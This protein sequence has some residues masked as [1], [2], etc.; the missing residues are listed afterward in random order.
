MAHSKDSALDSKLNPAAGS[1]PGKRGHGSGE[2]PQV[3][4]FFSQLLSLIQG[5]SLFFEERF[6]LKTYITLTV[7]FAFS[8]AVL[9]GPEADIQ[10]TLLATLGLLLFF[11]ELRIMD[12]LKDYPKDVI[13]HPKRPLPQE[14]LSLAQ[15]RQMV[16]VLLIAMIAFAVVVFFTVGMFTSA[17]YLG[18]T[19]YLW[20]MYREFYVGQRLSQLPFVYAFTH[21]IILIPLCLFAVAAHLD[22]ALWL[23]ALGAAPWIY[24][25]AVFGAFFSYEVCRK[26]DPKAHP[27]L[28]TYLSV[29]GAKKTALAILLLTCVSFTAAGGLHFYF[30]WVIQ[31]LLGAAAMGMI[32]NPSSYKSV[33]LI[34]TLSLALHI[35]SVP[36]HWV[37]RELFQ[38]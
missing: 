5:W 24:S 17:L 4:S 13:A 11:L 12:E 35:W 36:I 34:A 6:P 37:I 10:G 38:S 28:K 18:I 32:Q 29:Y 7:G 23:P 25:C 20:L 9:C 15:A 14:V 3:G 27:I 30:L 21:Q 26:L 8:G 22:D 19:L 2:L 1:R 33:E 31:L 16:A